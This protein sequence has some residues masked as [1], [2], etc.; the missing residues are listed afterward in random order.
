MRKGNRLLT[1]KRG[2]TDTEPE[3]PSAIEA[4]VCSKV[5]QDI[6]AAK[7]V[8]DPCSFR[9]RRLSRLQ[10]HIRKTEKL[11]PIVCRDCVPA[12]SIVK[13][14]GVHDRLIERG[15]LVGIEAHRS[16]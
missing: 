9:R 10:M 4:H 7:R 8:C 13:S 11:F 6:T 16:Q 15:H 3:K 5:F 14:D 12:G 2:K 1:Q